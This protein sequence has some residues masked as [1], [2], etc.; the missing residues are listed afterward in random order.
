MPINL[1]VIDDDNAVTELLS[2]LLRSHGYDVTAVNSGPEGIA[3]L[4]AKKIDLVVLDLMMPDMDGWHVCKAIREFSN[5]PILILSALDSPGIVAETL[6]AGA[7][8]FLI[9][10]VASSILLAHINKMVRRSNGEHLVK[11]LHG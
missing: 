2:L 1:L 11:D 4:H 8:D 6:N 10:P 3:V 9:K 5:L 7:D